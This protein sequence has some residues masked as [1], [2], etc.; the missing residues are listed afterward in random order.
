MQNSTRGTYWA[1]LIFD[2]NIEKNP[3]WL[4]RLLEKHL[5][6]V[7]SPHHDKDKWTEEDKIKHPD[8]E[9]TVGGLKKGHYHVMI[10]YDDN[11]TYKTVKNL[12]EELGLPLPI[13]V[14][15]ARGMLRYFCHQDN[16]EKAQYDVNDVKYYNG[17][18][19]EDYLIELGKYQTMQIKKELRKVFRSKRFLL[20][21]DFWDYVD[22][23]FKD[24]NYSYIAQTNVLYFREI[25]KD[26]ISSA[27]ASI[28]AE[29][30]K[31]Q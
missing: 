6:F 30:R 14:E 21:S 19:P 24:P 1:F 29:A 2:D 5:R 8:R 7:V 17:A 11:T 31:M 27:K 22:Q 9:F 12:T 28:M 15:S 18:Q 26:N 4:H 3:R 10:Q 25:L 20:M 16:P 13:R 23:N